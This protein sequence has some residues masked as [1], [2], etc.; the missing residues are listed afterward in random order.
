MMY[1]TDFIPRSDD[2]LIVWLKNLTAYLTERHDK[3]NIPVEEIYP[4]NA[5]TSAFENALEIATSPATR[6]KAAIQ[7]KNDARETVKSTMR[8]FLKAYVTYNRAV[9]DPD[10]DNM[11]LPI[12]K[13][14]RT[15]APVIHTPPTAE[16]TLPS[17]A[18]V[19]IEFRDSESTGKAKP[20]GA[21]GVEIAW[22]VLD[23]PPAS[24]SELI[25][26]SFDTHTPYRFAF[27]AVDSGKT[28]YFALRWEN[29]RGEKGPWS[30]IYNSII[31]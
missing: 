15:P 28:L 29:T 1:N 8:T 7:A 22:A 2:Q 30:R 25:H 19:E 12:H 31:P 3:W 18:V 27:D 10:R 6:T 5:Q 17:Q 24:W 16:I 21:H 14:G 13:T 9:T 23:T 4:L 26:S 20:A 11:N